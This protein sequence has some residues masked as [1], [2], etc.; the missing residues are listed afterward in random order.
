MKKNHIKEI[1]FA[2][3][4]MCM[5]L[6]SCGNKS[7]SSSDANT[8]GTKLAA[9]FKKE[10]TKETDIVKVADAIAASSA[11]DLECV[12]AGC[13]RKEKFSVS[14]IEEGYLAGFSSDINGFNKGVTIM[15]LIG[16]IPFVAYIFEV[17][18]PEEFKSVLLDSADP[19]WNICTQADETVCDIS[20]KY[21]FFTMCP[22]ND[23]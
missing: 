8:M 2:S 7:S 19:R 1:I 15:P 9:V 10:I 4:F 12:V 21:V 13:I 17:N 18:N 23:E 16:S 14:E 22:G 20:G 11:C 6:I 3:I 5:C